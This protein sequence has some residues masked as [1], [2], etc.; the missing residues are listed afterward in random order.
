MP[1]PAFCA[2]ASIR[3]LSAHIHARPATCV[4]RARFFAQSTSTH[5]AWAVENYV[6]PQ[7]VELSRTTRRGRRANPTEKAQAEA[8]AR[9]L[10]DANTRPPLLA[11][12]I[13]QLDGVW[14][15][16]YFAPAAKRQPV[17]VNLQSVSIRSTD[18]DPRAESV[19][20]SINVADLTAINAAEFRILGVTVKVSVDAILRALDSYSVEVI[21]QTAYLKVGF[22]PRLS[23]SLKRRGAKGTLRTSY[24]SDTCRVGRGGETLYVLVKE[25]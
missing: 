16:I 14:R 18:A 15:L 5:S 3:G 22:L 12:R 19:T 23:W 20:Q 4:R 9:Q 10:E 21:F 24:L 1:T 25:P 17:N 8:L 2:P 6:L 11:D 13:G 7:L